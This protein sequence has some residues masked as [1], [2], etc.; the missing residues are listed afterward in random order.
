MVALSK[1]A[2]NDSTYLAGMRWR[3]LLVEQAESSKSAEQPCHD[4]RQSDLLKPFG[5]PNRPLLWFHPEYADLALPRSWHARG[6]GW[7]S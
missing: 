7:R 4:P 1:Q 6:L 2:N 3:N 5:L